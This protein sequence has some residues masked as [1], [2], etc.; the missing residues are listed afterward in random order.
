MRVAPRI[1]VLHL[2]AHLGRGGTEGQLALILRHLDPQLV[3][4]E[5]AF[6]NPS[7]HQVWDDE[8][9]G[10]GISVHDLSTV[11]GTRARLA[12]VA[13]ILRRGR[14]DLV[15][16]WTLH[17]NAYA[18]VAGLLARVPQR[19]GSLRGSLETP[20]FRGLP[21]VLQWLCLHGVG[22]LVVNAKALAADLV[23]A[24]VS[25]AK[26]FHLPNAVSTPPAIDR[27]AVRRNLGLEPQ[28]LGIVAVGN[29]RR[30]K[31]HELAIQAMALV[32]G[33]LP[34]A[35][36]V[37]I[38]QPLAS[39][40]ETPAVLAA[41]VQ[42]LGL[43]DVVHFAGFRPDAAEVVAAFELATLTS[44]SEGMPNAVLEAMVAGVPTVAVDVGG[45]REL[46]GDV[47]GG[48]V[49]PAGDA[50]A[51]AAGWLRLLGNA[52]ERRRIGA[53]VRMQA[54]AHDPHMLAGRLGAA[55][56]SAVLAGAAA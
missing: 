50:E 11:H 37:I 27:D 14:F 54:Q 35:R 23:A 16:S 52:G 51:L 1:R 55:Y 15:H 38:G 25:S 18:G 10:A 42:R 48:L 4:S 45:V 29:L 56:R 49:V 28:H 12:A 19:W 22:R 21:R 13:Q 31:N 30:I 40:P 33:A 39:E 6:F 41:L 34:E 36:L 47:A 20:G 5:V 32:R 9:A 53:A 24:G 3:A 46:L 8:L 26:L 2:I 7:A 43:E 17:L 44:H